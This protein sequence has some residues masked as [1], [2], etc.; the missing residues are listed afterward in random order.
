MLEWSFLLFLLALGVL[1]G[2]LSGLLG[3]GGGLVVVPALAWLLDARGV[4]A[5]VQHLALGSSLALMVLTSFASV[6]GHHKRGAVDWSLVKKMAPA[7]VIG[8]FLGTQLAAFW[9]SDGLRWFFVLYAYFMALQ[10]L[11]DFKPKAERNLPSS[12]I[13][14]AIAST[15]GAISSWIGIG[16]A[17]MNVPFL[18]WCRVDMRRAIATSAAIG[19]P[20]ALSGALGYAVAGWQV[21]NLPAGSLGFL[22]LPAILILGAI[23]PFAANFGV[24]IS[25][26]LPILRLKKVFAL[27]LV[28]LAS[29]ML[30]R[31]CV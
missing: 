29:E 1:T 2:F 14:A 5:H 20:I 26:R 15:I 7:T 6:R 28:V 4:Q 3:I 31:L 13:L 22:Y 19:W 21:T 17:T 11:L 10:M 25:Y 16:G 12:P 8:T 9:S 30:Y 18:L 24:K 27:L 23:T